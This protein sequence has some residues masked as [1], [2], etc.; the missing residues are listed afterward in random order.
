VLS[1]EILIQLGPFK[2]IALIVNLSP[3]VWP[4]VHYIE[5]NYAAELPGHYGIVPGSV[6]QTVD[7]SPWVQ[8]P[9]IYRHS[10]R[11]T[12]NLNATTLALSMYSFIAFRSFLYSGPRPPFN[13]YSI[14]V[15]RL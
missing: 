4:F 6:D 8:V 13:E 2:E 5:Q 11:Q 3:L 15:P 12:T 14:L 10:R 7:W 9:L 1:P